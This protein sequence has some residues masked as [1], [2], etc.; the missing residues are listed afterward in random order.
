MQFKTGGPFA[1]IWIERGNISQPE[2][3]TWTWNIK[4]YSPGWP[5]CQLIKYGTVLVQKDATM[6]LQVLI[7]DLSIIDLDLSSILRVSVY[8]FL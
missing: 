6:N 1:E 3:E 8:I 5:G 2:H 7:K 4:D